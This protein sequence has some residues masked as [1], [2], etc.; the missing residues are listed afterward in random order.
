VGAVYGPKVYNYCHRMDQYD[1]YRNNWIFD[2]IIITKHFL[3]NYTYSIEK[4]KEKI[5]YFKY[6]ELIF[7]DYNHHLYHAYCGF[8]NSGF[9]EAICFSLDA[10]GAIL[11]NDE[12]EIES[13]YYFSKKEEKELYK[14][15]RKFRKNFTRIYRKLAK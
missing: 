1:A 3:D 4:I 8:Y 12:I 14:R 11:K 6:Q 10:S 2:K 13:I 5:K 15:T 7:D 9:D